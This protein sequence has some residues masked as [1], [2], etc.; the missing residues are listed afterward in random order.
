MNQFVVNGTAETCS[1]PYQSRLQPVWGGQHDEGGAHNYSLLVEKRSDQFAK[2]GPSTTD[3]HRNGIFDG[4]GRAAFNNKHTL[5]QWFCMV[6]CFRERTR[7]KTSPKRGKRLVFFYQYRHWRSGKL[8]RRANGK[9]FA[10]W[11]N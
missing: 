2:T 6:K 1:D 4:C 8:V 10:V 7:M 5:P 3:L 11:M 9:P